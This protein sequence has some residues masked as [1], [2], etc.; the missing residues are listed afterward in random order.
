MNSSATPASPRPIRVLL[1]GPSLAILGGQSVQ[2]KRLLD[3]L[4]EAGEVL[5]GF[6]PVNPQ[7]PGPLGALQR[8]KYVRTV[9]TSLAYLVGLLRTVPRYDV[10]HAFS[11]SYWSFILAPLPAM[12]VGRLFGKKVVLNYHSGEAEDHLQRWRRTALPAMRLAHAI[13]VPSGYLV[14]VFA[15]FGLEAQAIPNF[16]DVERFPWRERPSPRPV[17]L[18]NRNLQGLYNVGCII[19]AFAIVR[20]EVPAARLLVAG[21]GPERDA[22]EAL[23]HDLGVDGVVEFRGKLE[24]AAMAALYDEADVYLNSPNIDNMPLSLIEASAAGLPVVS[25]DAGGIPYLVTHDESALLVPCD[26]AAALA[27]A[28]LRVLREPGLSTRL[29]ATARRH[30]LE[31]YTWVATW[32]QWRDLYATLVRGARPLEAHGVH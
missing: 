2:L 31:R 16:V 25:T 28:A 14:D 29:A 24:P 17:F 12:L 6:L 13:V 7:L 21:F 23:A 19:R 11:A 18:S 8:V 5:P 9:V 32:G 1:V 4:E 3:K 26:D 10:I 22:L 27:A 30:C 20:R 15:R